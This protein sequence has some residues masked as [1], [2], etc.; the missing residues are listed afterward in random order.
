MK[1][2]RGLS[3]F[4]L[5]LFIIVSVA[6]CF[7]EFRSVFAHDYSLMQ[8]PS[9]SAVSYVARGVYFLMMLLASL[10]LF[11]NKIIK[12]RTSIVLLITSIGLLA[13]S[14]PLFFYYMFVIALVIAIINALV[15]VIALIRLLVP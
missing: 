9:G 8:N 11:I 5:V 10:S 15:V 13:L 1:L 6:L 4:L 7:L 14:I 12:K 2:L 3:Y